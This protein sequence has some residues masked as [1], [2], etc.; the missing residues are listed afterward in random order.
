MAMPQIPGQSEIDTQ[1]M[2]ATVQ[3]PNMPIGAPAA[4]V[5]AVRRA[6]GQC[7]DERQPRS[8]TKPVRC[9]RTLRGGHR[10]YLHGDK[11]WCQK[12]FGEQRKGAK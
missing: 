6:D 1:R 5:T 2:A 10:L 7:Q 3:Y 9:D 4:Y 12:H 8:S 11:V